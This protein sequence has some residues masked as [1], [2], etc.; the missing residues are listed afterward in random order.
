MTDHYAV[1]AYG[2]DLGNS[3]RAAIE[4]IDEYGTINLPWLRR[5]EDGWAIEDLPTACNR[6]LY[7]AIP[8]RDKGEH[9]EDSWDQAEHVKN[10]YGVKILEHGWLAEGDTASYAL[11]ASHKITLGGDADPVDL[12]ERLKLQEDKDFDGRLRKALD[13]L[14]LT[15]KQAKPSWLLMATR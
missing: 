11:I 10:Y 3:D 2:Y 12:R 13:V 8:G 14:G 15:P 6:K 7:D 9:Q 4:E 1:L 5:D